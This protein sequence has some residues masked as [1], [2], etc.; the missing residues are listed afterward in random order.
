M[1]NKLI[2]ILSFIVSLHAHA[3]SP[4]L[5]ASCRQGSTTYDVYAS[6]LDNYLSTLLKRYRPGTS[7]FT[8][9]IKIY[10]RAHEDFKDK[11]YGKLFEAQKNIIAEK[12]ESFQSI[13]SWRMIMEASIDNAYVAVGENMKKEELGRSSEHYRRKIYDMCISSK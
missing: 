8:D 11:E 12:K 4:I 3:L 6:Y 7:E 10:M 1:R 5:I 9:Q 2:I 13:D